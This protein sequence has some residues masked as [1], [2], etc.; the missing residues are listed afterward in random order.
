MELYIVSGQRIKKLGKLSD[1]FSFI[2]LDEKIK[3][4]IKKYLREFSIQN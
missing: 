4:K 2:W 1:L 3:I